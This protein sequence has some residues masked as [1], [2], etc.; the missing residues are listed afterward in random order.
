MSCLLLNVLQDPYLW[1]QLLGNDRRWNN[2]LGLT[3]QKSRPS[4]PSCPDHAR[5][6]TGISSSGW[7]P[8]RGASSTS[9]YSRTPATSNIEEFIE[10]AFHT[11]ILKKPLGIYFHSLKLK[12]SYVSNWHNIQYFEVIRYKVIELNFKNN[13]SN[14]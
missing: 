6:P 5:L 12:E 11:G 8:T 7:R 13:T 2:G 4:I 10:L 1:N 9:A 14:F 3:A